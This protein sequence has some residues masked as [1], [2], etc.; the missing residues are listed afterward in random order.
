MKLV[1]AS[2][3]T[4]RNASDYRK[5]RRCLN[6]PLGYNSVT[7]S[8]PSSITI[9]PFQSEDQQQVRDLIL[10]GLEEHWGS[11]DPSKNPDLENIQGIRKFFS[12]SEKMP[13]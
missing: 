5:L 9:R 6:N 12:F 3:V 11:L 2:W 8:L 13:G 7:M 1:I 10:T 4:K